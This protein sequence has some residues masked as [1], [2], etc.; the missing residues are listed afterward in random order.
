MKPKISILV[1]ILLTSVLYAQSGM[2]LFVK[3]LNE[4]ADSMQKSA[5][6]A[7]ANANSRNSTVFS[8]FDFA[9]PPF[10]DEQKAIII[11]KGY[12][13]TNSGHF[14]ISGLETSSKNYYRLMGFNDY[15][16]RVEKYERG[17]TIWAISMGIFSLGSIVGC[18]VMSAQNNFEF[19]NPWAIL[20]T[21]SLV[22]LTISMMGELVH[23]YAQP[24]S[25]PF[26]VLANITNQMNRELIKNY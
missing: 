12:F 13:C 9:F 25:P 14:Y 19:S 4:F 8:N 21:G 11:H 6:V 17:N 15:V 1:F 23:L 16:S 26:E 22:G 10:T 3:N 24:I 2:D 5:I 7:L 20:G 18:W